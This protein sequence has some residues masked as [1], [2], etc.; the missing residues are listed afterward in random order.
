M[1]LGIITSRAFCAKTFSSPHG[2]KPSAENNRANKP[3]NAVTG[4]GAPKDSAK[5]HFDPIISSK[6][7]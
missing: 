4:G 7:T 5:S 3:A 1:I 2:Q 6:E